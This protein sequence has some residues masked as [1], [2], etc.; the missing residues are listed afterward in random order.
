MDI[1]AREHPAMEHGMCLS[2]ISVLL[3]APLTSTVSQE[4]WYSFL[5]Y[6]MSL[7]FTKMSI[8]F[9]YMRIMVHGPMRIANFVVLG[10][11]TI[12][13]IWTFIASFINCVPLEALW[14]TS[15][16]GTCLGLAVTLGNSIMH[17]I[18]DFIIFALPLPVLV[19]LRINKKQKVGL[20]AVFSL[21]FL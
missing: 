7:G 19:K 2:H 18:T 11:V 17:I 10:I 3:G 9:L 12:C 13:N 14:N 16:P 20:I 1:D 21:G 8:L 15:V 5:F 6:T 4:Q